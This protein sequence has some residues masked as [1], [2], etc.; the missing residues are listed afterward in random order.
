[1]SLWV[2]SGK[3]PHKILY[4]V[5]GRHRINLT[6]EWVSESRFLRGPART[7]LFAFPVARA[8]IRYS[9]YYGNPLGLIVLGHVPHRTMLWQYKMRTVVDKKWTFV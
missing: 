6:G 2:Y 9:S 1:M 4:D 7:G 5:R 8:G 3:L